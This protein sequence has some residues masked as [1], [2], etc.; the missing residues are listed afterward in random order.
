MFVNGYGRWQQMH[1]FLE[2]AKDTT[3]TGVF[4]I[5]RDGIYIVGSDHPDIKPV[6]GMP[7]TNEH[8][9]YS[10]R[11]NFIDQG[12]LLGW[13]NGGF[14]TTTVFCVDDF[15]IKANATIKPTTNVELVSPPAPPALEVQ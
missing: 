7:P 15:S 9:K 12:Y 3:D 5:H 14:R 6:Y 2:L 10:S 1:I 8:I 13:A 11:G 4:Q